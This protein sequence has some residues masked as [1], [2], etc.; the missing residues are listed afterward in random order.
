[1]LPRSAWVIWPI[2]SSIVIRDS[3]SA[4]RASIDWDASAYIGA[5]KVAVS[6]GPGVIVG[7]AGALGEQDAKINMI[8]LRKEIARFI[9]YLYVVSL[10]SN[11]ALLFEDCES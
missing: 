10:L 2:F 1:M 7:D 3:K 4:T 5:G 9:N 8:T 11:T 6:V